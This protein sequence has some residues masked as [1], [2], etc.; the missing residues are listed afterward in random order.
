VNFPLLGHYLLIVALAC[1][2]GN[3]GLTF[4]AFRG[5]AMISAAQEARRGVL[6]LWAHRA[7]LA[8]W[9][10][11]AGASATL[12]Y[13]FLTD[14]FSVNYVWGHS[15]KAQPLF[16]KVAA[17]WGGQ[18]GSLLM[19][20]GVL[21]TCTFLVS[22]WGRKNQVEIA[23]SA[24]AI[25]AFINS[26]F[27]GL[28]LFQA[29]PFGTIEGT[30]P[31]DG[32]GL[33]PLLQNY[34]MQ[35]HPPTLYA[36][37]IGCSVPFALAAAALLHHKFDES[38]VPLVRRWTLLA[39]IV[40]FVGI[41]LGGVW[42][43]ET[44][45]WGGYWAWD[46]VENASLMPWIVLT[47]FLH[48]I[49]LQ[50]RRGLLKNWN[51]TLVSLTFLLTIF[52]TFLTRSGIVSSV[53]SFAESDIGNY[54]LG[55]LAVAFVL[56]FGLIY[57]RRDE[58]NSSSHIE[59]PLSRE[60]AFLAGNWL[61]LAATCAVL[62]GT[63][64]PTIYEAMAG[65]R[66]TVEQSYF[67]R[68]VPP[69]GLLILALAGIGPLMN[70]RKS[71]PLQALR[72]IKKPLWFAI[73]GILFFVAPLLY[74]LGKWHTGAAT[75]FL[76]AAFLFGA[77]GQ[78]FVRGA[79]ARQRVTRENF[80]VA[81][82]NAAAQ[83]RR[84][85][86]GYFVHLGLAIFFVGLTGSSVFKTELEPRDLKIGDV[87]RI[88]EYS[89]RFDGFLR[90]VVLAPEKKSDVAAKIT[91]L[92]G[93]TTVATM[94]PNVDIY[95]AAGENDPEAMAGQ[96]EQQARRPA[97]YSTLGHDLYLALIGYDMTTDTATI[98]AYLNPL[99]AWI[100]ISVFVFVA[101]SFIALLPG[102]ATQKAAEQAGENIPRLK[103]L[104]PEY[105]ADGN[106]GHSNGRNGHNGAHH[107]AA[108]LRVQAEIEAEV[109][110]VLE[111]E[112]EIAVAREKFKLQT[113][114]PRAP[115]WNCECGR[116]MNAEDK[117]CASCGAPKPT[118]LVQA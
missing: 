80:F 46:P 56:T 60:A 84:R 15:A 108:V 30:M 49:M 100:W 73:F 19:W 99:V 92:K 115:G 87:L 43:Y 83:N 104:E 65:T 1:A 97:I 26:F 103:P 94:T 79:R 13:L 67:N 50:E 107:D 118:D 7:A 72:S 76:L 58:L 9:L 88:G 38:W 6:L 63:I 10:A 47:A 61:L 31:A 44:L 23:P 14:N 18:A 21:G 52:G 28:I 34:W 117:F 35:I 11:L 86:G 54:F 36:G 71:T 112:L 41:V 77:M 57:A 42:A 68:T 93:T 62:F 39:W 114:A 25:L 66:I 70:W 4:F 33:N 55:F 69:L 40:L 17:F 59:S 95:K 85:F 12:V 24:V 81:L 16:Y 101:G 37:Y 53:H 111:T 22:R 116:V 2:I 89:L 113:L 75:A 64:W 90:P 27:L 98:K 105:S 82:L 5:G 32:F 3:I 110:A 20:A 106:N 29:N 74:F 48:S 51:I 45:G 96:P 91:V 102:G 78:E 109:R 8:S